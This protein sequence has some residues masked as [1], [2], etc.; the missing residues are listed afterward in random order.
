MISEV[1]WCSGVRRTQRPSLARHGSPQPAPHSARPLRPRRPRSTPPPPPPPHGSPNLSPQS[2]SPPPL[3]PPP[4]P[5]PTSGAPYRIE[6]PTLI[7]CS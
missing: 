6:I 7:L 2:Q 4:A 3:P 5:P 1:I